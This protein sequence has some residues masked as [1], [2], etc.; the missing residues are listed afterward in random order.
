[1]IRACPACGTNNRIPAAHL[2]DDGTCGKCKA[3]LPAIDAPLD[4]GEAEFDDVLRD[5]KV[6]LLVDF[7]AGWCG[8]CRAAAPHVKAVAGELKGRALVLKVDTDRH[9]Q[10][11]ARFGV[12]G[13]PHFVVLKGGRPVR[14]QSGL[15]DART[16]ASWLHAAGA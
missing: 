8:P 1:M 12:R 2:A 3:H 4:V 14:E 11:A 16:M 7:W 9:P 10:L 15:T 13:I 6:P 5:A